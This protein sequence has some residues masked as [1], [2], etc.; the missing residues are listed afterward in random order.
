M[1]IRLRTRPGVLF[2]AM[3]VAAM[4]V[5]LPLRLVL[6]WFG[7]G[8]HG[9]TAR[10]VTGTVWAGTMREASVGGIALGDL[11]ARLSPWPLLIG[12]ARV[13]IDGRPDAP[14]RALRGAISL[15][16]HGT[17]VDDFTASLA[18]GRLFAPLPV[19]SLDLDSVTVHFSGDACETAEGRVRATLGDSVQGVALPPSVAGNARCDGTAL[20]LPL[21]SQAGTESVTLRIDAGGTYQANFLVRPRDPAAAARLEAAG[22][23]PGA[24]GHR[25]SVQGRF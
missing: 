20:L 23:Q 14:G 25:L 8:D 3:L 12:R 17:G 10:R 18:T 4:L 5:F 24:A 2:C 7:M 16:R 11:R 15:S 1:R 9:L 21:T 22:F 6:G 13:D 19:T